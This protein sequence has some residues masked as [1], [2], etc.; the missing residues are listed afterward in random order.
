VLP[1]GPSS[2]RVETRE[3]QVRPVRPRKIWAEASQLRGKAPFGTRSGFAMPWRVPAWKQSD[4][5]CPG[6]SGGPGDAYRHLLISGEMRRRFGPTLAERFADLHEVVNDIRRSQTER[7][8]Q[9]D[10]HNNALAADAPEFRTWED[11]VAWARGKIVEAAP[12][13]GD[14]QDGRAFWYSKQPSDWRPDFTGVPITPIENG[15]PEHRYHPDHE[16]A[17]EEPSRGASTSAAPLDR[18][19]AT[20]T[21]EDVRAVLGSPAYLRPQ[22]RRRAEA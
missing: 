15:G 19:V 1:Y 11:V 14:G 20:W 5:V 22:H 7:D 6:L 16:A 10:D 2:R 4:R 3:W 18:P 12:Q 17:P 9:M 13:N 8:R 21:E